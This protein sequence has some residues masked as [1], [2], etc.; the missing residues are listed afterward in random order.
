MGSRN[1]RLSDLDILILT[2]LYKLPWA[3]DYHIALLIGEPVKYVR[4]RLQQL[5]EGGLVRRVNLL[6]DA[7]ALNVITSKG[8][9]EA[10]FIPRSVT[11]PTYFSVEHDRGVADAVVYFAILQ[12]NGKY[13][14]DLGSII[15]ERD[16]DAVTEME[17][18]GTRSDGQPIYKSKSADI[19]APD[20]YIIKNG[21]YIAIEFERTLKSKKS[22]SQM[23]DNAIDLRKRFD[24]QFWVY[25][26]NAVSN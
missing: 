13:L 19:H 26:N 21:K 24:K 2:V 17:Q 3:Q 23:L 7:T 18:V 15:T 12:R 6:A 14:T 9:S 22:N 1:I 25:G 20:A 5:A 8:I 11:K 16:F 10:G 4:R